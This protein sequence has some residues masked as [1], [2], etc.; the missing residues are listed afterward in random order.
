[1]KKTKKKSKYKILLIKALIPILFITTLRTVFFREPEQ[2]V[3]V[4]VEN[5]MTSGVFNKHKIKDISH[6]EIIFS[7]GNY[8]VVNIQGRATKSNELVRYD[9][10]ISK[11]KKQWKIKKI[12]EKD[13]LSNRVK[14][15]LN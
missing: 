8:A 9:V 13:V 2:S 1:M 14:E 11:E 5:S 7:D 10:Y 15:Y 3:D 12:T 6:L 4:Y